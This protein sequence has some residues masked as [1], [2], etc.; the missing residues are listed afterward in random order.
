MG[1]FA[2]VRNQAFKYRKAIWAAGVGTGLA[3]VWSVPLQAQQPALS[4]ERV[5]EELQDGAQAV[6]EVKDIFS[7]AV[8]AL[9]DTIIAAT[10]SRDP[11]K[12]FADTLAG[13]CASWS[14]RQ[15]SRELMVVLGGRPLLDWLLRR[16]INESREGAEDREQALRTLVNLL[17]NAST[18]AAL[19]SMPG[20]VP[21]LLHLTAHSSYG[22]RLAAAMERTAGLV[23]LP[24][25]ASLDDIRRTLTRA[26]PKQGIRVQRLAVQFVRQWAESSVVNCGK[27]A[28]MGGGQT[29]AKVA[30]AATSKTGQRELQYEVTRAMAVLAADCPLKD[31]LGIGDWLDQLLYIAADAAAWHDERLASMALDAFAVCIT[32]GGSNLQ[33]QVM[34][35]NVF[36]LLKR[37]SAEPGAPLLRRSLVTT[38]A[39]LAS[40]DLA[41]MPAAVREDWTERLLQ[42]LFSNDT[43]DSQRYAAASALAA[44]AAVPGPDGLRVASAWLGDV[45]VYLTRNVKA[46][47]SIRESVTP[48]EEGD[49]AL[50]NAVASVTPG[51]EGDQALLNAVAV[52]PAFARGVA[53]ELR[54]SSDRA[55]VYQDPPPDIESFMQEAVRAAYPGV[56][57]TVDAVVADAILCKALK[58]LCALVGTDDSKQRW[59]RTAGLLPLLQRLTLDQQREGE[60][61]ERQLDEPLPEAICLSTRRQ[62]ARIVAMVSADAAAEP[63]LRHS[64]WIP[65][66]LESAQSGDCKLSSHAQRALLHLESA[67][68][69]EPPPARRDVLV[70]SAGRESRDE[71]VAQRVQQASAASLRSSGVEGEAHQQGS[72]A[73]GLAGAN[74]APGGRRK[75]PAHLR[76]VL[77]DGVHMFDPVA[78]HHRVL[79]REGTATTSEDAPAVDVVFV[80]GI[81]GGA[82]SS[83]RRIPGEDDPKTAAGSLDH[84]LCWPS[85]WLSQ[86][87]PQARLL[88]MEYAAPASGWEGESLPVQRTVGQL[89]D[90]LTAAGVGQRPVIFICHSM[91]GVLVKDLLARALSPSAPAHHRRLA[92]ATSGLVFY[93]CP[94]RGSWLAD[95]GWNLR[96]VGASP[97]ASVMHLRPGPH[98]DAV[99][100]VLRERHEAGL[101]PVLS[102]GE[103]VPTHLVSM[104]PKAVVVPE[105]SAYPGYGDFVML[106][107]VDH[108]NACKPLDTDD[109]AYSKTMQFVRERVAEARQKQQQAAPAEDPAPHT[110]ASP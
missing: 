86:D 1:V 9:R 15:A 92:E 3:V 38:L 104:L 82:F 85:N 33:A 45:L 90:R 5:K 14:E 51:E 73:A 49:Q 2:S 97:A 94:H 46:Y 23:T 55:G 61:A 89:M 43:G 98:L 52:G 81:R 108:I 44:L 18:A 6:V 96:Y 105:E 77:R 103:G 80:H 56:A 37:L 41:A 99:N 68:H 75:V 8:Q 64:A 71:L 69:A 54:A 66:L 29:L 13:Q 17:S 106:R 57:A 4:A 102:F 25:V 47:N 50:L 88:S 20:V 28:S 11:H 91:G 107:D 22:G 35:S 65:W 67:R 62:A 74:D 93:T 42:W 58:V 24:D 31:A 16:A 101:L 30:A 100:T 48:G 78:P 72:L 70:G 59:L 84:L 53:E 27:I 60:E 10:A 26:S 36:A 12:R 87:V 32:R 40:P 7:G 110:T 19:L 21:R 76:L 95:I 39:A 83:W 109:L 34:H 63:A 79:A